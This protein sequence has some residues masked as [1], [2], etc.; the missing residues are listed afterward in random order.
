ME[1]KLVQTER[2]FE[3]SC[4]F[5]G[6]EFN[7]VDYAIHSMERA[8]TGA[9]QDIL[10]KISNVEH[11]DGLKFEYNL[12]EKTWELVKYN[13]VYAPKRGLYPGRTVVGSGKIKITEVVAAPIISPE[14]LLLVKEIRKEMQSNH[15]LVVCDNGDFWGTQASVSAVLSGGGK[16]YIFRCVDLTYEQS[17]YNLIPGQESFLNI[18]EIAKEVFRLKGVK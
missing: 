2:K 15:F 3:S 18:E 16:S 10:Y 14:L 8:R 11:N 4:I 5:G 17:A 1:I 9:V 12:Q 6:I 7:G 13:E